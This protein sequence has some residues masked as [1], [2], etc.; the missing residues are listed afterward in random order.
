MKT[1]HV[2][3]KNADRKWLMH[4]C[5]EPGVTEFLLVDQEDDPFPEPGEPTA[6]YPDVPS[7][8]SNRGS[9]AYS[10]SRH[11]IGRKTLL[12]MVEGAPRNV[13]LEVIDG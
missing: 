4:R 13:T 7:P 11:R 5:L 12:A 9:A 10:V 3:N 1:V 6:T 2:T 8:V